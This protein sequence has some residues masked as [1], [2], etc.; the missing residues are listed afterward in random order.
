M[1][2]ADRF[3][4]QWMGHKMMKEEQR[5]MK[6]QVRGCSHITSAKMFKTTI[7]TWCKVEEIQSWLKYS[8][9]TGGSQEEIA[10]ESGLKSTADIPEASPGFIKLV[11]NKFLGTNSADSYDTR[12]QAGGYSGLFTSSFMPLW[13]TG[14]E[15]PSFGNPESLIWKL[16]FSVTNRTRTRNSCAGIAF[17]S[18]S[19]D[20]L[21]LLM[22]RKR[23]LNRFSPLL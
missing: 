20:F 3:A 23:W 6:K 15:N 8:K 16:G 11:S 7:R 9:E 13:S 22:L 2:T 1:P 4:K 5:K 17:S 10:T 18:I 14:A 12:L 21:H 19:F